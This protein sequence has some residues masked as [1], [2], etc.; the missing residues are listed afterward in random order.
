[1]CLL[2]SNAGCGWVVLTERT[3]HYQWRWQPL[4]YSVTHNPW[5]WPWGDP[6]FS[7]GGHPI[8]HGIIPLKLELSPVHTVLVWIWLAFSA[9]KWLLGLPGLT[10]STNQM[11]AMDDNG[12]NHCDT[13]QN[14]SWPGLGSE[15]GRCQN[16]THRRR[17]KKHLKIIDAAVWLSSS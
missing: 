16:R 17:Q 5:L 11:T 2:I 7:S 1:M 13:C 15:M 3:P 8:N 10:E 9:D 4:T 12:H 14:D 6:A